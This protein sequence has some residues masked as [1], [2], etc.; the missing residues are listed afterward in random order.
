VGVESILWH[1]RDGAA[2]AFV[3]AGSAPVRNYFPAKGVSVD[4]TDFRNGGHVRNLYDSS[5]LQ[6]NSGE[7]G[8][9]NSAINSAPDTRVSRQE[10]NERDAT[11][12]PDLH[13]TV[14]QTIAPLVPQIYWWRAKGFAYSEN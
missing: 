4:E 14:A 7:T 11:T 12:L 10:L 9:D 5:S 2:C 13:D 6:V 1:L 8:A 3:F